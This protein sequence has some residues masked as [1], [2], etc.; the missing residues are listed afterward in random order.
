MK[1]KKPFAKRRI[2]ARVLLAAYVI[3]LVINIHM[4][5]R[6]MRV[7]DA[8]SHNATSHYTFVLDGTDDLFNYGTVMYDAYSSPEHL[9]APENDDYTG[10]FI[11]DYATQEFYYHAFDRAGM[12]TEAAVKKAIMD[13][14]KGSQPELT[15]VTDRIDARYEGYL[16]RR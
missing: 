11:A 6:N 9:F 16:D 13:E 15:E 10:V 7:Y 2:A 12:K 14:L 8:L 1:Q 3:A 4:V 5:R